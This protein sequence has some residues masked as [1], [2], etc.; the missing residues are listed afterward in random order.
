AQRRLLGLLD[1]LAAELDVQ[2]GR[3]G[4]FGGLD[5]PGDVRLGQVVGLLGEVDRGV[6]GA[7]VPADLR[8]PVRP[9]RADH[10]GDLGHRRDL[11]EYRAYPCGDR[12]VAHRTMADLPDDR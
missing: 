5:D 3:T 7:A 1:G 8:G 10:G 12:R 11:P 6:R 2:P 4:R 9:V